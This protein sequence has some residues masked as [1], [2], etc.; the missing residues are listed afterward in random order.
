MKK[1]R[2]TYSMV[3]TWINEFEAEDLD[4]AIHTIYTEEWTIEDEPNNWDNFKIDKIV[5]LDTGLTYEVDVIDNTT[6]GNK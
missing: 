6:K 2:A 1:Y 4:D 5:D 3:G